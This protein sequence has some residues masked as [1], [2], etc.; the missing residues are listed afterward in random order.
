MPRV[1]DPDAKQAAV[2]DA[3]LALFADRTFGGTNMPDLARAA[4]V[5]AGTIYRYFPSKEALVNAVFVQWKA[6]MHERLVTQRP[7]DLTTREE[8]DWWW[9]GLVEFSADHPVAFSF[10]ESHRHE[11]YLDERSRALADQIDLAAMAFVRRGQRRHEL[12]PGAPDMLVALVFGALVGLRK[13]EQRRGEPFSRR[14]LARAHDAAWALVAPVA[15]VRPD[16]ST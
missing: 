9:S 4:G 15:P 2:L 10:L 5:A 13:V 12:R 1:I 7:A 8:F 14:D 11:P 6:E 3:A 16:T